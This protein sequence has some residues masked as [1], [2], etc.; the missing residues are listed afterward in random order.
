MQL[1][2]QW[3]YWDPTLWLPEP[4]LP[5]H[6][7]WWDVHASD[8]GWPVGRLW[9]PRQSSAVPSKLVDG[10]LNWQA[11]RSIT[12]LTPKHPST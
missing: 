4:Q 1:P 8:A 11:L 5:C 7:V 9:P 2:S 12:V 3:H 6:Q 10:P